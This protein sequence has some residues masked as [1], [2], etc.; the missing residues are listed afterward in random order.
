M[1]FLGHVLRA[2]YTKASIERARHT[3]RIGS[4]TIP[5]CSLL[6]LD[7]FNT[8]SRRIFLAELYKN[9]DLH[10]IIPLVEMIHSRD[11]TVYYF[12]LARHGFVSYGYPTKRSPWPY[13]VQLGD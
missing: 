4:Q 2:V 9:P 10:P 13:F 11:S 5:D 12:A 7:P 3:T 8:I 6:S 1:L